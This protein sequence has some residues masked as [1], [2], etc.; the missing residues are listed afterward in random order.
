MNQ[1]VKVYMHVGKGGIISLCQNESYTHFSKMGCIRPDSGV[2][3]KVFA[4]TG[5]NGSV[6]LLLKASW[7]A[8]ISLC[9]R[10]DLWVL[11]KQ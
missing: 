11:M 7:A 9:E 6:M 1:S 10:T 5:D 3:V 8:T 4:N 2:D